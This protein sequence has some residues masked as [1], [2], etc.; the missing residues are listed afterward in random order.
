MPNH[1]PIHTRSLNGGSQ[2]VYRFPNGYGASL[3]EGGFI[4]YGGREIGVLRFFGEGWDDYHLNYDTPVT[5][6]VLGYLSED[7]V[8]RILDQIASLPNPAEVS[9]V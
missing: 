9:R 1:Q 7:D 2:K 8:P 6:D 3:I 4:A 5:S